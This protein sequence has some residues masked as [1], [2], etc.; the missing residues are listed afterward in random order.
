M[1]PG[2]Q[3]P[4]QKLVFAGLCAALTLL[5]TMVAF[6]LP[7]LAGAYVN[8]GDVGVYLAAFALGGPVGALSAAVGSMLADILLGSVVYALPTFLIKGAMA[9]SASLLLHKVNMRPFFALALAGILMPIG[10][11]VFEAA[12]YSPA[13]A[14]AGLLPNCGQY[15]AGVA[16]GLPVLRIAQSMLKGRNI[17]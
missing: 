13:A 7:T 16:L 1:K 4:L 15:A 6:P 14:L 2:F 17:S 10:Y 11:F 5:L 9:F 3:K 8:L 12:L